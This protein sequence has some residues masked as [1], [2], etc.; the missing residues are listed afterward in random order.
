MQLCI[1]FAVSSLTCF[2]TLKV[3]CRAIQQKA[4][5]F[6]NDDAEDQVNNCKRHRR[7][8]WYVRVAGESEL[9]GKL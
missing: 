7:C 6:V 1:S 3:K 4:I 8:E 5:Q 9:L 2:Q